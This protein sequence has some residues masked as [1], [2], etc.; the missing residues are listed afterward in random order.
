MYG[1]SSVLVLI[2]R[3]VPVALLIDFRRMMPAKPAIP[4]A[5]NIYNRLRQA[6][7]GPHRG[8]HLGTAAIRV[9]PDYDAAKTCV[10]R[11]FGVSFSAY[12]TGASSVF[13]QN[14]RTAPAGRIAAHVNFC[15]LLDRG[16]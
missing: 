12:M 16:C 4:P 3:S 8:S 6:F 10:T 9:Q 15:D 11:S 5:T 14:V 1:L 7:R 2:L 13:R